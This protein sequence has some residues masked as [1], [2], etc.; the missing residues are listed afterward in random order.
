MFVVSQLLNALLR[1]MYIWIWIE[2]QVSNNITSL[3]KN[4]R[5]EHRITWN[6]HKKYKLCGHAYSICIKKNN[7]KFFLWTRETT[8]TT[9]HMILKDRK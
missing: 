2:N 7:S 1:Y 9:I 3:Y 6:E 5:F 8:D 4:N